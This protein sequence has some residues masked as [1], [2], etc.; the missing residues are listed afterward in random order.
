MGDP[1]YFPTPLPD[2]LLHVLFR[3]YSPLSL[4][5]VEKQKTWNNIFLGLPTYLSSDLGF[6]AILSFIYLLLLLSCPL[7]R[8]LLNRSQQNIL[9]SKCDFK[10]HVRNLGY[11]PTNRRPQNHLSQLHNLTTTLTAYIILRNETRYKQSGSALA[12][13]RGL[14]HRSKT[15]WTL[16]HKRLQIGPAFYAPDVNSGY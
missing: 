4:E 7:P 16:V 10:M 11:T 1:L 5:V 12:T 2:C 15:T 8:S 14:L 6:T 13:R 9:G 3:R